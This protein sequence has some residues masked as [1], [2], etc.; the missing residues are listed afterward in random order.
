MKLKDLNIILGRIES[1]ENWRDSVYKSTWQDS[2]KLYRSIAPPRPEGRSNMFIPFTFMMCET[3]KARVNESLFANRP[4]VNVL[5]RSDD[6]GNKAKN[7]EALLDW[8]LNER[9]NIKRI[10]SED[11]LSDAIILGTVVTYTGWLK[12]ERKVR[13]R[14]FH[15]QL[16]ADDFGNPFLDEGF[17]PVTISIPEIV[18][19]KTTVYD[20]PILQKVDLFDFFV[21]RSAT[22]IDNARFCGHR[23]W[24]TKE[25]IKNFEKTAGWQINWKKV[26]PTINHDGGREIRLEISGAGSGFGDAVE[27]SFDKND[28]GS[29]YEV[30]HYWEDDRHVVIINRAECALD[31][32]NPFWHGVKPY[33]KVCYTPL[34]NEFYGLGIPQIV[35]DLQSELN[36]SRNM[37]IDYNSMALRRM[38]KIK[39]G[40]DVTAKDLV[41]R[42]NGVIELTE[43]D[44]LEQIDAQL[45]PAS[46]FANEEVTKQDMKDATG[47]HDIILGLADPN[48]TATT[49]MT[50]DNNASIRFKYFIE[51]IVNCLLVPVIDKCMSMNRQYLDQNRVIRLTGRDESGVGELFSISPE[52][53]NFD[54]DLIYVGSSVEPVGNRELYRQ[55]MIEVFNMLYGQLD[56]QNDPE[57]RINLIEELLTAEQVKNVSALLPKMQPPQM[58]PPPEESIPIE[59]ID[60]MQPMG[61]MIPQ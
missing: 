45:L 49:T 56:Y 6:D 52:D 28:K 14:E 35:S 11:V 21:D 12:K 40:S 10:F 48:E 23:E 32:P 25:Q 39:K 16:L 4:Y 15:D 53:M 22:T 27:D 8:Q 9:M 42:Q 54:Y 37:R 59:G 36:T 7:A 44:D 55:K 31:E 33:D 58:A 1:A 60:G 34:T 43:L 47:V 61:G 30:H 26:E 29:M 24:L 46:A 3:V 20:D 41:W 2:L 13:D 57:A 51:S 18:E 38:W 5:G 19:Q 50:K 17:N